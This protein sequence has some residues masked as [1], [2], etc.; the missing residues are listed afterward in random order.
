MIEIDTTVKIYWHGEL[1]LLT[2]EGIF[3]V[4]FNAADQVMNQTKAMIRKDLERMH[5]RMVS[6]GI[7]CLQEGALT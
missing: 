4:S 3:R 6:N 7:W 1:G 2:E 5:N